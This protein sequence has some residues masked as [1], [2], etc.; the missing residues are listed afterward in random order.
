RPVGIFVR[1]SAAFHEVHCAPLA[2]H[3]Y[4]VYRR[5]G[6]AGAVFRINLGAS[7]KLRQWSFCGDYRIERDK[8]MWRTLVIADTIGLI[9][10]D[11]VARAVSVPESLELDALFYRIINFGFRE[12]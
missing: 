8:E 10:V 12:F 7:K 11:H 1:Q 6:G 9:G 4:A 2:E 5:K 3:K